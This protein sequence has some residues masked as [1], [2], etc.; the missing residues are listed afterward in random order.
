ML[1]HILKHW[2]AGGN[3][4]R[5]HCKRLD[6]GPS[7]YENGWLFCIAG[8]TKAQ[9]P[10]PGQTLYN[11]SDENDQC[12]GEEACGLGRRV[13]SLLPSAAGGTGGGGVSRCANADRP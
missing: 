8:T 4:R 9:V 6:A 3:A 5:R 12:D 1:S 2:F 10:L 7:A 11:G 13:G